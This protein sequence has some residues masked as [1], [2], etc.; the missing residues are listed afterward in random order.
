MHLMCI[1]FVPRS[2]YEEEKNP[3]PLK[4]AMSGSSICHC[5]LELSPANP[6][7]GQGMKAMCELK[8]LTQH[9]EFTD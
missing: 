9:Y 8:C 1:F 6:K 3:V 2:K 5:A 7:N 4:S